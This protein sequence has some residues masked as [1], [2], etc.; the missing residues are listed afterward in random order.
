[1]FG[2]KPYNYPRFT[3]EFLGKDLAASKLASAGPKPGEPA[4]DFKGRTL[5]GEVVRLSD[6]EGE[7]NVV[8]A[9]GSATC[10]MTAGSLRGLNDLYDGFRGGDVEFF[11]VYVR[12]AHPG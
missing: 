1:M 4:P 2:L 6:F 9:F 7:K 5:D 10:P 3:R 11:F 12:E 8:L